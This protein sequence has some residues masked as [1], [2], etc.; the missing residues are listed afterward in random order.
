MKLNS[1][2]TFLVNKIITMDIKESYDYLKSIGYEVIGCGAEST[3]F[4]RKGYEYVIKI[5]RSRSIKHVLSDIHFANQKTFEG[6]NFNVIV[7]EKCEKFVAEWN[8]PDT[9][10]YKRWDKFQKFLYNKFNVI[11]R[12]DFNMGL[13][14]GRLVSIDWNHC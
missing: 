3:V 14:N 12:H 8:I 2:T 5:Q 6:E 7:Q 11:D 1:V 4:S 13:K 9:P 10:E